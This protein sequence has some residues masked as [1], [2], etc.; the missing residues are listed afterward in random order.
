M[1]QKI[2]RGQLTRQHIITTATRLFAEQGYLPTSI[3]LILRACDISRGA[4]Y[5]HFPSKE[6]VFTAVVEAVE[7]DVLRQLA[8]AGQ[9]AS[10]AMESLTAGCAAWL[11]MANDPVI[12]Q[13]VLIDAPA[14]LGWTAWRAIEARYSLGVLKAGLSAA[15]REGRL[16]PNMVDTYAHVMLAMLTELAMLIARSDNSAAAITA[17][18][19][20]VRQFL[21]AIV[22]GD[23]VVSGPA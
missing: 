15:A 23:S 11:H 22:G 19:E 5:H 3:E 13:I 20:A 16:R 10:G 21:S 18:E 1:D 6:A 14:V 9:G 7:E 2:D 8:A 12:R 4:L 17:G